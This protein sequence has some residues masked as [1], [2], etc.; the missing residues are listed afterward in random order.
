[1]LLGMTVAAVPP[2]VFCVLATPT[3]ATAVRSSSVRI[4]ATR[5]FMRGSA[6]ISSAAAP[7]TCGPAMLV[8]DLLPKA[9]V[10]M[11]ERVATPGAE[12]LGLRRIEPSSS[13]G[14]RLEKSAISSLLPSLAPTVNELS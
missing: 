7:A 4:S 10:G 5:P 11:L 9:L 3:A 2:Q 12:M 6:D 13:T 14:P 8:P 1:M